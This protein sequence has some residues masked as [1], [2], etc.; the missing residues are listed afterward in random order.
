MFKS[1]EKRI[2]DLYQKANQG[3]PNAISPFR[4]HS[5]RMDDDHPVYRPS[6]YRRDNPDYLESDMNLA[7]QGQGNFLSPP[8]GVRESTFR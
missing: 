1:P 7:K 6:I 5:I 8:R 2:S 3:R 4:E